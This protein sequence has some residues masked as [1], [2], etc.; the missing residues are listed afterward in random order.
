MTARR[1]GVG[2]FVLIDPD[3]IS[4]TNLAT[5]QT[6]SSDV[7]RPKVDA[8]AD[9]IR[10]INP[11]AFVVACKMTLDDLDDAELCFLTRT[12]FRDAGPETVLLCGMTDDFYA[13]AR[14][15]RLALNFGL[16]SLC[17]QVYEEGRGA[18]VTFTHPETTQACHRCVLRS[19]YTAY[20]QKGFINGVGS[21]GTPYYATARLNAVKQFVAMALL[22]HGS[23]HPR[24]GRLLTRIGQ[25]NLIQLR[26][27]PDF[28]LPGIETALRGCDRQRLFCDESVWLPQEI[29][30]QAERCADCAAIGDL[31]L[32]QGTMSDTR[33]ARA[34]RTCR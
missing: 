33:V 22:H 32:I 7:G 4:D 13:Q 20:L 5:Q 21:N 2:E 9:R 14:V 3:V 26:L 6:Y 8:L 17:A 34:Q 12:T 25:R 23:P 24:W 15:N 31:R 28:T 1:A 30:R 11:L 27:E 18:E 29:D 16:P 10:S 19:R